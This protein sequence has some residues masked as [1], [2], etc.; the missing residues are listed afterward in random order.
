MANVPDLVVT[1]KNSGVRSTVI[2]SPGGAAMKLVQLDDV[3]ALPRANGDVLTWISAN[4]KFEFHAANGGGGGSGT[5]GTDQFARDNSNGAFTQAN[6]A[7][8]TGQAAFDKANSAIYTAAQIRANISNTTPI[9]YNSTTGVVS[10]IVPS[11]N[12]QLLIGNTVSGGYDVRTLTAGAGL[13]ITNTPG[14][15]TISYSDTGATVFQNEDFLGGAGVSGQLGKLGWQIFGP[16]SRPAAVLD[17][18][19]QYRSATAASPGA[20]AGI[21]LPEANDFLAARTF[22]LIFIARLVQSDANTEARI[23]VSQGA[24]MTP[25]EGVFFRKY[26]ADTV[27]K[28]VCVTGGTETI[29]STG[30]STDANYH[31]FRIRNV[32][33]SM[34]FNVNGS[35]D[36]T[37]ATNIPTV[38][39]IMIAMIAT[40]STDVKSLDIDYFA[41]SITGITRS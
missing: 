21:F 29:T 15:V 38:A 35:A 11:A 2:S 30:V 20:S 41:I 34:V 19:G 7:N 37:I 26:G 40:L 4:A 23:G 13:S 3:T 1:V 22:E 18:P 14:T 17:H 39:M 16:G 5:F 27:W 8:V 31:H 10:L 9:L 24:S 6:T 36:I 25:T 32:G 33:G 28:A 12:G